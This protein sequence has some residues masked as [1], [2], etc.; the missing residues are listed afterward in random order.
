M[1]KK[2][3]LPTILGLIILVAGTFAGVFFLNMRQVFRIGASSDATPKDVR[4]TN[5]TSTSATVSWITDKETS[6]FISLGTS[7]GS[8]KQIEKE[9]QN[10]AKYI[11]HS[12]NVGGLAPSTTYYYKI[13][14]DGVDYN[15]NGVLWQLKTGKELGLGQ[16]SIPVSGSVIS[17]TGT[18]A[19][20]A[21]VYLNVAGYTMST[22]TSDSGNFIF[23]LGQSRIPDLSSYAQINPEQTLLDISIQS[24][25]SGLAAAQ[26]FP[27]SANPIPVIIL[28]KSYDLRSLQKTS[29]EEN[30]DASISLPNN[31]EKTSKFSVENQQVSQ[32]TS[33]VILESLDEG[34]VVSSEKPQFFGKG[35]EGQTITISVH[36]E[37]ELTGTVEIPKGGSWNWSP[38]EN[39]APGAHTITVSWLD[40]SGITRSLKRNF[41]VQ[42]AEVPAFTASQSGS[43]STPSPQPTSTPV[44]GVPSASPTLVPTITP[45][46]TPQEVPVTGQL[47]PTIFLFMM[48]IGILLF[49]FGVWKIAE[50]KL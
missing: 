35:P 13:N 3:K 31:L 46:P 23:Q 47:T 44:P 45:T 42:A 4:V 18:P 14:S 11:T 17:A 29:A 38:P 9:D 15:N 7:T 10:D 27:K 16:E 22:L 30:P 41:V 34:E 48:S 24:G 37:H 25:S 2:S 21:L 43:T 5:L 20:R 6:A 19:K 36:S 32:S 1:I 8:L 26:V 39:L 40:A 50:E 28:G 12:I 33:S 49:S